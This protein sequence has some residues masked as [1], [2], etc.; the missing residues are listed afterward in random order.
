MNQIESNEHYY[1]FCETLRQDPSFQVKAYQNS[2]SALLDIT[3]SLHHYLSHKPQVAF[4]RFGTPLLEFVIPTFLRLQAPINYKPENMSVFQWAQTLDKE[5]NFV[6]WASEHEVTGEI[7]VS[8]HDVIEIHKY[9]SSKRI[10]S[11]HILNPRRQMSLAEI[12]KNNYSVIVESQGL[13]LQDVCFVY[14][15]DKMK[16]P[17]IWASLQNLEQLIKKND[18]FK[19][20][21]ISSELMK[22]EINQTYAV[23][24]KGIKDRFSFLFPQNT[25]LRIREEILRIFPDLA[26]E[27]F[28]LGQ[29]PTWVIDSMKN[30]WPESAD[31]KKMRHWVSISSK[32]FNLNQQ[33]DLKLI[34]IL[35]QLESISRIDLK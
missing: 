26:S 12:M 19:K 21:E 8:D 15:T 20:V 28:C 24:P 25:G 35:A 17:L 1:Q 22:Y 6:V 14:L 23:A 11:I 7:L 34:E 32:A 3:L 27:V 16:A 33:L 31:E 18:E 13:F 30:W 5:T 2:R 10:F 29:H 4:S 9:F